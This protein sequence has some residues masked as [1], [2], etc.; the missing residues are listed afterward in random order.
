MEIRMQGVRIEP[1]IAAQKHLEAAG[2][3]VGDAIN[4][5]RAYGSTWQGRRSNQTWFQGP[6]G[7]AL[8]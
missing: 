1:T 5:L 6:Q 3:T 8:W 2:L 7:T 4:A